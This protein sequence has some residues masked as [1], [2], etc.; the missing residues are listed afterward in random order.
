ML[1][2]SKRRLAVAALLPALLLAGAAHAL[3]EDAEQPVRV[4]ADN[5][6]FDEKQGVAVYRGNVQINQGTLEVR[7]DTLT[8]NV[9][10]AGELTTARTQGS[11]AHY[12]QKTDPA[13]GP[14]IAT[15][16]EILY[17]NSNSVVTLIGNAFLRQDGASFK[18]P[19]IVYSTVNKRVE[20]S[21]NASQR[22][23][24]VFPPA[25]RKPG[26]KPAGAATP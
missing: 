4:L 13:K 12:Q 15:A 14:V 19:R 20:A 9:N 2:P 6:R 11:P 18:G 21:G 23:Q 25:A 10:A 7:G 8:L 22:V 5:A 26:S 1:H 3:P 24:L 17:D 16:N